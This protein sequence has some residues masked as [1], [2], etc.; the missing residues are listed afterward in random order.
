MQTLN[1]KPSFPLLR[2]G[3]H[4]TPY[5]EPS[6]SPQT[7]LLSR[8]TVSVS[9]SALTQ[10]HPF[11][12][13]LPSP[14]R[15]AH[16]SFDSQKKKKTKDPLT[17]K[18][19]IVWLTLTE[20]RCEAQTQWA[21]GSCQSR[22]REK[23]DLCGFG[24]HVEVKDGQITHRERLTAAGVDND[25]DE[26]KDTMQLGGC[27]WTVTLNSWLSRSQPKGQGWVEGQLFCFWVSLLVCVCWTRRLCSTVPYS[28]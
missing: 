4:C 3:E 1:Q 24:K 10:N 20:I 17:F 21:T 22:P 26:N 12:G 23:N 6:L 27:I 19:P 25:G 28:V 9:Q 13:P 7:A 11:T 8:Q 15:Q 5:T 2:S 18:I 14:S 16:S